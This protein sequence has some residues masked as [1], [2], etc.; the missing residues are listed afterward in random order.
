MDLLDFITMCHSTAQVMELDGI[1]ML[2]LEPLN[3]MELKEYKNNIFVE[4]WKTI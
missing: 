3:N 1:W 2:W 4:A